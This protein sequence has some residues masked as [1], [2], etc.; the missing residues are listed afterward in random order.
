MT[1]DSKTTT[2]NTNT[3]SS[4]GTVTT[5]ER[6]SRIET[7]EPESSCEYSPPGYHRYQSNLCDPQQDQ[8]PITLP[9]P[10]EGLDPVEVDPLYDQMKYGSMPC[11]QCFRLNLCQ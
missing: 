5:Q 6:T 4:T 11:D 10:N 1:K 7:Y 8:L 3:A 2:S 9:D